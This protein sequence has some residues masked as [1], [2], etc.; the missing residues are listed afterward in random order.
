MSGVNSNLKNLWMKSMEV[1]G[2]TASNIANNTRY[3]VDEMNI[4]NR[5]REILSDFGAKAYALWQKGEGDLFPSE[6]AEQLRELSIL[7][8][9]LNDMRAE[10]YAGVVSGKAPSEGEAPAD[11]DSEQESPEESS[12]PSET[13]EAAVTDP[14]AEPETEAAADDEPAAADDEPA[15]AEAVSE[16]EAVEEPEAESE[17]QT[18]D[19]ESDGDESAAVC[20]NDRPEE[21]PV[22]ESGDLFETPLGTV[23]GSMFEKQA[24]V[25]DM[26]EKVNTAL[27]QF[28]ANLKKFSD[29]MN[30]QTGDAAASDTTD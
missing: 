3:K 28:D 29:E 19:A 14:E 24:T 22:T 30:R 21:I 4:L 16:P 2:K 11:T 1:I 23:I 25:D 13:S 17:L 9:K 10:R 20:D 6:L 26:A 8:E 12:E 27:D 15:A 5:K 7:D 18:E